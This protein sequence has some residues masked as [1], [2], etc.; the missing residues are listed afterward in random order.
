MKKGQSGTVAYVHAR[1]LENLH[2]LMAMG[3]LPGVRIE[4]LQPIP[5]YVFQ[6]G[7]SQFAV[8][9]EIAE[10]IYVRRGISA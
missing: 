6:C 3:V 2:K 9:R 10:S 1:A 7:Q 5:S 8:D 4:L